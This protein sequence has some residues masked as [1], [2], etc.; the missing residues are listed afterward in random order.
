MLCL[1]LCSL[2]YSPKYDD[3]N[4]A[5]SLRQSLLNSSDPHPFTR[6]PGSVTSS[7]S[8]SFFITAISPSTST[9][10]SD[11]D[12]D[13]V[14]ISSRNALDQLPTQPLAHEMPWVGIT[15]SSFDDDLG[16]QDHLLNELQPLFPNG[17]TRSVPHPFP[18][19]D[20]LSSRNELEDDQSGEDSIL[21]VILYTVYHMHDDNNTTHAI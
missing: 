2:N 17:R 15:E 21:P 8:R 14:C 6:T 12:V 9:D 7:P 3:R 20:E 18:S 4:E 11:D 10:R 13:G 19:H 1:L 16:M 5:E